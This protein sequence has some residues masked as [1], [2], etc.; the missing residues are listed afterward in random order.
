MIKRKTSIVMALFLTNDQHLKYSLDISLLS[1]L[2]F[3]L[4][5]NYSSCSVLIIFLII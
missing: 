1:N 5:M 4:F 2:V 3:P